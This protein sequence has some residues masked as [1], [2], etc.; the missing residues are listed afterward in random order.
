MQI[1]D[2]FETGFYRWNDEGEVTVPNNW[3]PDWVENSDTK[4]PEYKP[5]PT[6]EHVY[7]GSVSS[8]MT[9]RHVKFDGI[10][11]RVFE[12]VMPGSRVDVQCYFKAYSDP[13]GG[14]AGRVGIDPMGGTD[15]REGVL[16]GDFWG[17]YQGDWSN[18]TWH[19]LTASTIAQSTKVTVFLEARQDWGVNVT[20]AH[21]DAFLLQAQSNVPE[22]PIPPPGGEFDW[23]RLARAHEA[24]AAV[25]RGG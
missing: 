1:I 5:D 7:D 8:K 25:L 24:F 16:W 14:L 6:P 15:F 3:H 11:Y 21:W 23:E 17:Q 4:R 13:K 19:K 12:D 10:L 22:P 9:H 20:A 2:S 18:S